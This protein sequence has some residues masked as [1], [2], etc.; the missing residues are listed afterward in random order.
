[1]A[2]IA[3]YR[4]WR[5]QVFREVVG[6]KHITQ[7]L[8]NSLRENRLSHAYLFS[9]PRGTGKTSTA[10]ILAKAVNCEKGPNEEPCNECSACL[11]IT[12]GSVMDVVEID[13]ASNRG[14]EEIRDIRDRVKYA[15][16][17]VRQKVYIIDEVHM[18]TTEAFNALL[19]TLEE[20]PAHVMFILATTEPHRL[21]ATII[22]RCQR[23]DF[24]R[25]SLEE[26]VQRLQYVCE[27]EQI[28]IDE[29]ALH[30]IARLSDGGMRDA[31][32]LLDQSASFAADRIA[33]SD[34]LSI[35]G[36]VA[37]DQFEKLVK[38]IK[39]KDLG[40]ALELIDRFMQE[41]KSADKCMESLIEYFR[42]LLMV[43]MVP[44][45]PAVT[46]RIFDLPHLQSV[47]SSFSP[48][49]M[50][51]M[52]EVLNHYQSEMKYSVQPQT[53]LEIAVMKVSEIHSLQ[54]GPSDLL[55][56]SASPTAAVPS[57]QSNLLQEMS[58][59]L[60]KLED[61]LAALMKSG[62]AVQSADAVSKAPTP[63]APPASVPSRKSGLKLDAYLQA[64]QGEETR[65]ALMKWGQILGT[66]KEKKI[67]VHAWLVNGDLVCSQGDSLLVAFKNEMHRDTTE[68]PE[69]KQ[70]IEQVITAVLGK[71]F[72]LVTIMRKEWDD[73]QAKAVE[74]PQEVLELQPEENLNG[75][76]KE[77]WIS[78]AIQLFGEDL[79]KINED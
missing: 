1:M 44:N 79:V 22:S 71:P 27:Q 29:E 19:K 76:H 56:T 23:F 55:Q 36:G 9:G 14:V 58:A 8:Q 38:A 70:L 65:M 59:K 50:M 3:L 75:G 68:K 4:T 51:R 54:S 15:P 30:Y 12:E 77:E 35:T 78:E 11:R 64:V 34:I 74:V 32:S 6:Q 60:L 13:A 2:H 33:I 10:K 49:D 5:S 72:R 25:V 37:S 53:M 17:E 69:N 63:K 52:I 16:T 42:D 20:P 47:A 67:T 18:L 39:D 62:V 31:L 24:R 45:S 7:T 66:V 21:P 28:S 61:Q 73:A 40:A 57:Q 43:R 46:E 26:Q 48:S 41:G